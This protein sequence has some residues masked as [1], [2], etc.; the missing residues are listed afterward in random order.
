LVSWFSIREEA[1]ATGTIAIRDFMTDVIVAI[2]NLD[3]I[4][5]LTKCWEVAL[6]TARVVK[7][8]SINAITSFKVI[9]ELMTVFVMSLL[10]V[11]I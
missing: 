9:S 6:A 11:D 7:K 2:I 3:F 5:H 4:K 10:F 8:L 1:L